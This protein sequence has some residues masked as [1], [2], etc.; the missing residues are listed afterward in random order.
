MREDVR[1][2][3]RKR[4][5]EERESGHADLNNCSFVALQLPRLVISND[6]DDDDGGGSNCW[7][8]SRAAAGAHY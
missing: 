4:W 5:G 8:A 3:E 2:R 1:E 6:D 7:G